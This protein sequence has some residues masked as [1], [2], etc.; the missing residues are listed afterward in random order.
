MHAKVETEIKYLFDTPPEPGAT[1]LLLDGLTWVRVPLP[2]VLNHVNCWLLDDGDGGSTLIDTGADKPETRALWEALFKER[3]KGGRVQ[4]LICTHGHPDHVGLAGWIV[5]KLGVPLHMT[6]AEWLAPQVWRVEGSNPMLPA[7]RA[8]FKSHGLAD[9]QIDKMDKAREQA[10]FRNYP[11]PPNFVRMRDGETVAFGGRKWK[12]LVNGGHADEHAS[13]YCKDDGILIAGDQIL[14]RISPVVGV[15]P[16]QPQ[17]NPLADYLASLKRLRKLPA[18]T[19]VLPSH[20]LPFRGLHTRIDQLAAHHAARLDALWDLMDEPANA[21]ALAHRLFP[22]AMAAQ[23]Q[24]VM[25][26]AETLA[27]AHFL[28][29]AKR[30]KRAI[31]KHGAVTFVRSR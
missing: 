4:R 26:L 21:I 28:V 5:D 13:F 18:D 3:P 6:L 15:F 20:G 29:A 8:F 31:D 24:T 10:P 7:T 1:R 19:I 9:A 23:G 16:S 12:V 27:H 14:S 17:S 22:K 30:A 25:A 11:L 2:F